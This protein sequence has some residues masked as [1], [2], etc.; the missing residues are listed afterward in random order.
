M[1]LTC[2]EE[3]ILAKLREIKE[4]ARGVEERLQKLGTSGGDFP[5]AEAERHELELRQLSGELDELRNQ[6]A[7]WT[8]KL[9]EAIE[10]KWVLLGHRE[11]VL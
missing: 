4:T 2:E 9:D 8:K 3:S 11:A 10:K 5:K 6:W 1:I 7:N